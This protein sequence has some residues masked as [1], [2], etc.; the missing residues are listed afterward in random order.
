MECSEILTG[1]EADSWGTEFIF[2]MPQTGAKLD[3]AVCNFLGMHKE[4]NI[5]VFIEY[6]VS[7]NKISN[8]S[9]GEKKKDEVIFRT[10]HKVCSFALNPFH[11]HQFHFNLLY[12]LNLKFEKS[13]N[14][15]LKN[16]N[17]K[18]EINLSRK[19]R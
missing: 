12:F 8:N 1:L 7:S 15:E 13:Q 11:A 3:H 5:T 16:V 2:A 4:M 9:I 6:S 18:D 14:F 10:F 17:L 19:R